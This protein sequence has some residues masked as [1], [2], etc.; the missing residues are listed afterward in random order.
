[1]S[2]SRIIPPIFFISE[3][4]Q[5]D[6]SVVEIIKGDSG[7][8]ASMDDVQRLKIACESH[9]RNLTPDNITDLNKQVE[10]LLYEDQISPRQTRVHKKSR[11]GFVYLMADRLTG[12][13]KIGFSGNPK[14]RERTLQAERP[15]IE[16]VAQHAGTIDD[17]A[18]LHARF[19][20]KRVRGEWFNLAES[21]ITGILQE[22]KS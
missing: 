14:Y 2:L 9:L 8:V 22:W 7:Y 15:V 17:E 3:G 13:Y 6:G 10:R 5:D 21:D 1:M 16:L 4:L 19:S 11:A 12:K 18:R 20:D